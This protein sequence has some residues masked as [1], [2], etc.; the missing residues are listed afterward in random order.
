M[1]Q[2]SFDDFAVAAF[3]A[4]RNQSYSNE[5][6]FIL[7][8][9]LPESPGI[10]HIIKDMMN[11]AEMLGELNKLLKAMAPHEAEIRRIIGRTEL[12]A[13]VGGKI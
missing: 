1:T 4:A 6:A 9:R 2:A 7:A 11:R 10:E 8:A 3:E 12:R 13:V 5:N